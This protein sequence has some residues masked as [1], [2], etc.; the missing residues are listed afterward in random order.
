MNPLAKELNET[1]EPTVAYRLLSE[2]GKRMYFPKGIVAQSAEAT[3]KATRHNATIGMAYEQGKPMILPSVQAL[4]APLSPSESVAYAPVTGVEELRQLWKKELLRKNPSLQEDRISLPMVVP[5]LTPGISTAADLF[6]E[7]DDVVI[8]PDMFWDNY[9][10]IFKDRNQAQIV[11]YPF[12]NSQGAYNLE[13]LKKEILNHTSR[14]KVVLLLNFPNNPAGYSP[15]VQEA[16][17]L[18]EVVYQCAEK[19][20]SILTLSDDA[21]YGLFYE[22]GTETQS[23]FAYLANLHPRVL[24]VKVDG[25]TKEDFVWGFRVAFLTFGGKG[26]EKEH[27]DALMVKASAVL[28]TTVSNSS[29]LAQ[30]IMIRV[31][32]SPSYAQEKEAKYQILRERYLKVKEILKNRKNGKALEEVPFNSGY[33]MSFRCNGI[34]AE[35]LRKRLLEKGIGTINLQDRFLR[36]AFA[37]VDVSQLDDLYQE[38][39]RTAD[40][41]AG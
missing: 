5:G 33:F 18:A 10:L 27:F 17:G 37:S 6:V 23:S 16:K 29:R 25:S 39:F 34:S 36:V 40:E 32:K 31:M 35:T 12:F 21:Y 13:G 4:T 14:G 19:G 1:L 7:K 2:T 9:E 28:R 11:T 8:I 30:S 24:A 20:L 15:T 3:K 26:L 41:L 38:I 22:K